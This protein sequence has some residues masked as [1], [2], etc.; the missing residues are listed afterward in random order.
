MAT[1]S[2]KTDPARMDYINWKIKMR[3]SH[4]CKKEK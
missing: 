3:K 1:L 4:I 2:I